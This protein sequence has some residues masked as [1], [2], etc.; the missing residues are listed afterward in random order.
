MQTYVQT[1]PSPLICASFTPCST[2]KEGSCTPNCKVLQSPCEGQNIS[3][4]G[5]KKISLLGRTAMLKVT[6]L[7]KTNTIGWGL[8]EMGWEGTYYA[9]DHQCSFYFIIRI[10]KKASA[11]SPRHLWYKLHNTN[12]NVKKMTQQ[13]F[14]TPKPENNRQGQSQNFAMHFGHPSVSGIHL[15]KTVSVLKKAGP[16]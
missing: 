5:M 3:L 13:L 16:E 9:R 12:I 6:K 14:C 2:H 7:S 1:S 11:L 4:L 10:Y 8:M 15:A